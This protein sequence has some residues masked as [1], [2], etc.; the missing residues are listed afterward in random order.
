MKSISL[1]IDG[2]TLEDLVDIARGGRNVKLT[3]DS[4]KRI[5]QARTLIDRWVAEEKTIYGITTGFGA[6][7]DVAISRKDTCRRCGRSPG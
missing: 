4:E 7:S 3:K 5:R 6:L 2:L 1:G